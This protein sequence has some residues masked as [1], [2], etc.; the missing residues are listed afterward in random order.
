MSYIMDLR[1]KVG[2]QVLLMPCATVILLNENNEVLLQKRKDN[3]KWGLNGGSIE[4]DENTCFAA[5]RELFEETGLIA[6]SLELFD[7]YSGREFHFTYPNGDEVNTIDIVYICRKYHGKLLPQ[8]E[9]V[10]ELKFFKEEDIPNNMMNHNEMIIKDFF[11]KE[12]R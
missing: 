6:D 4:L 2:H 5:K 11:K 8:K 3:L 12:K 10:L 7:V 1:K 9:E